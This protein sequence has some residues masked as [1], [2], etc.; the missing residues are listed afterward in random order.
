MDND[1]KELKR[2]AL[3]ALSF[4][5]RVKQPYTSTWQV[6]RGPFL[7][8]D[9]DE[10]GVVSVDQVH[11]AFGCAAVAVRWPEL[12]EG[13][14]FDSPK[15]ALKAAIAVREQW[16]KNS[17]TTVR[18][19]ISKDGRPRYAKICLEGTDEE[20][21]EHA[22]A[23]EE[24]REVA[25]KDPDPIVPI[26]ARTQDGEQLVVEEGLDYLIRMFIEGEVR[27]TKVDQT[28]GEKLVV[29]KKK[30]D[31]TFLEVAKRD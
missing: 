18:I 31:L 4:L 8:R 7:Y 16:A 19:V 3:E 30:R 29:Y 15:E 13:K 28:A 6:N 11:P 25:F 14:V 2:K 21:H 10:E 22:T 17:R 1:D 23:L 12:G 20:L 27:C 24:G 5:E 26:L 9:D